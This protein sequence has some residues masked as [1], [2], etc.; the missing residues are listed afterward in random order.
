MLIENGD[1]TWVCFKDRRHKKLNNPDL[2]ISQ[3]Y[4]KPD[5]YFVFTEDDVI[6]FKGTL[7]YQ[8]AVCFCD[9][10]IG[11]LNQLDKDQSNQVV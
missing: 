11:K 10:T 8:R 3:S 1:H 5:E 6:K 7:G 4:E 2:V 9:K